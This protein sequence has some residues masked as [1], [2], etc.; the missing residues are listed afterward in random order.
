MRSG[1]SSQRGRWYPL[2]PVRKH[3]RAFGVVSIAQAEQ[4]V[5]H[6]GQFGPSLATELRDSGAC[7]LANARHS[8]SAKLR[9]NFEP[10]IRVLAHKEERAA[11]RIASNAS[12][13]AAA[14]VIIWPASAIRARL[15]DR[16]PPITSAT[17]NPKST[18]G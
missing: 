8:R 10:Y 2:A 18:L 4:G 16:I 7:C 6:V 17:I 13:I 3:V 9:V 15:P 14:S 11:T 1:G 5:A 12:A